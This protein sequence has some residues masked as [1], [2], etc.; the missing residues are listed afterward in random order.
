MLS[1][2]YEI[3][4]ENYGYDDLQNSHE[5]RNEVDVRSKSLLVVAK[6]ETEENH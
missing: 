3:G 5:S 6:I 2:T 4:N 1:A